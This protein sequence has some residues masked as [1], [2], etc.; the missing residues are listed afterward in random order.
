MRKILIKSSK[1]FLNLVKL[2]AIL[3]TINSVFIFFKPDLNSTELPKSFLIAS[4]MFS[5]I[6]SVLYYLIS[7]KVI[8]IIENAEKDPFTIENMNRFTRT[9][10][11]LIIGAVMNFISNHSNV[12]RAD[13][14]KTNSVGL[15]FIGGVICFVIANMIYKAVEIK[16]D[17]ELTI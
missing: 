15:V 6:K 4:L 9:G 17:N 14:E 12:L 3:Y 7:D 8:K 11:Y 2:G 10:M 13:L 16:K 5:I 1:V